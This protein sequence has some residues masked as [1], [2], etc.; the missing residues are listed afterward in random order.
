M[1]PYKGVYRKRDIS[2]KK[3]IWNIQNRYAGISRRKNI[4]NPDLLKSLAIN[5]SLFSNLEH[6]LRTLPKALTIVYLQM[7]K[8]YV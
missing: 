3:S 8:A 6:D 2:E 4:N 7:T 1:M 5:I